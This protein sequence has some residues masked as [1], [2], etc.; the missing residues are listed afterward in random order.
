MASLITQH[1]LSNNTHTL[2]GAPLGLHNAPGRD[3][4]HTHRENEP[5]IHTHTHSNQRIDPTKILNCLGKWCNTFPM[6][7]LTQPGSQKSH[8]QGVK[9][10]QKPG[11]GTC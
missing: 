3:R 9:F 7:S 10:T 1:T 11:N 5:K 2:E 4:T 8:K 6:A